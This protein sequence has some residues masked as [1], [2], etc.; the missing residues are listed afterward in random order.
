MKYKRL[1]GS[2][3]GLGKWHGLWLGDDHL[4]AVESTGYSEEYTRFY[5]KDIESFI[6]RR[7][8][9]GKITTAICGLFVLIFAVGT[10]SSYLAHGETAP[11]FFVNGTFGG[12]F[13]LLL[14][15][16]LFRGPTCRCY[17][18]V[19]L[20]IE[21]LEAIDRLKKHAK[22]LRR[23]RPLITE[24]Q[25]ALSRGDLM[26]LAKNAR[27]K[28]ATAPTATPVTPH[29]A[30]PAQPHPAAISSTPRPGLHRATFLLL[31][32]C[33]ALPCAQFIHNSPLLVIGIFGMG[34]AFMALAVLAMIRQHEQRTPVLAK[35]MV[36]AG[37][38]I[39][40]L[41]SIASYFIAF[42]HDISR[43]KGDM[44]AQYKMVELFAGIKP[45]ES[46]AYAFCLVA[47]AVM[48][49][50]VGIAGLIATGSG[51]NGTGSRRS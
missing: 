16:N 33:G 20:G 25:G 37:V 19:P 43:V 47:F 13:L 51:N 10:A 24:R 7:T 42:F 31:I 45:A 39:V 18:S 29:T 38:A 22:V 30:S 28:P 35:K 2:K 26:D 1:T 15:W 8:A 5:L 23:I 48:A 41:G 11:G 40:W 3:R 21:K 49:A 32:A 36:W 44:Y 27:N 9:W 17:I 50:T 46:P 12:F 6:V 4:L 34:I 14:L